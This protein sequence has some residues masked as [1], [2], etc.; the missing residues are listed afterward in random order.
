MCGSLAKN[1]GRQLVCRDQLHFAG[2]AASCHL[3]FLFVL[4]SDR[5]E[6][7]PFG[8]AGSVPEI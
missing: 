1:S 4:S 7:R 6:M 5:V 2:P 3:V 8:Q